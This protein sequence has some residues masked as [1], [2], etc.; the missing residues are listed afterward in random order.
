[1][2]KKKKSEATEPKGGVQSRL[3]GTK[4]YLEEVKGE[5]KKVTWPTRK[6]TLST[7]VA[8]VVLVVIISIYLGVLDF[9][10][11]RLVGLILP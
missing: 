9:G 1:M 7:G 4:E 8:V 6:E 11:S 2:S 3:Q 10:L 5:L